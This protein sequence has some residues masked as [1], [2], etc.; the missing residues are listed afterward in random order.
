MPFRCFVCGNCKTALQEFSFRVKSVTMSNFTAEEVDS[1]RA[2]NGGGNEWCRRTF[3]GRM[4]PTDPL[5]LK[6]GDGREK[7]RAFV[8][9]VFEDRA[10]F[11]DARTASSGGAAGGSATPD[12][13]P[14]A[15]IAS[16]PMSPV[17]ATS[18]GSASGSGST[19][20]SVAG[21][22]GRW[23]PSGAA[24]TAA[25]PA[26]PVVASGWDNS[27]QEVGDGSDGIKIRTAPPSG[28]DATPAASGG[29]DDFDLLGVGAVTTPSAF[30]FVS[31]PPAPAPAPA[32]GGGFSATDDLFSA[33]TSPSMPAPVPANPVAAVLAAYGSPNSVGSGSGGAISAA[34]AMGPASAPGYPAGVMRA[35]PQHPGMGGMGGASGGF[36]PPPSL[37]YT[38]SPTVGMPAPGGASPALFTSSSSSSMPRQV[39]AQSTSSAGAGLASPLDDLLSGLGMGGSG[40]GASP[41]V[42]ATM[43]S[44]AAAAPLARTTSASST[45]SS[46]GSMPVMGGTPIAS[47][48]MAMNMSRVDAAFG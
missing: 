24:A 11:V 29:T 10:Y 41:S 44:P 2:R 31:S 48:P 16:P 19:P 17:R 14:V 28:F 38:P 13:S 37:G 18:T 26:K 12:A 36:M 35:P 15:G 27:H 39:S 9:R 3:M 23:G 47:P 21:T 34:F 32:P 40:S 43:G 30:A 25:S 46:M 1:L 42:T 33:M 45:T 20:F 8:Q 22:K 5:R 6:E 4:S 7:A